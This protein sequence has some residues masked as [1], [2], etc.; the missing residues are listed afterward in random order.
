[1]GR[2]VHFEIHADDIERAKAFYEHVFGWTYQD[3]TEAT[4]GF[5]YWGAITGPDDVP[6]INGAIMP[7]QGPGG[8]GPMTAFV[9]TI[10]VEDYGATEARILAG[11]GKL[12][13]PKQAIPGMAWQGYYLDTE[14][15]I[16]GIHQ[17]D[18]NAK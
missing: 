9:C 14:G 4:G 17:P 13:M 7:R 3:W 5:P 10:Q 15:N 18:E 6:G 12:A 16:I 1:M 11:G 2:V 8:E